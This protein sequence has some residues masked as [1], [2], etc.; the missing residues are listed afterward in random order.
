MQ[1]MLESTDRCV[2]TPPHTTAGDQ[3][4]DFLSVRGIKRSNSFLTIASYSQECDS[5]AAPLVTT[6]ASVGDSGYRSIASESKPARQV[7]LMS[8]TTSTTR[9]ELCLGSFSTTST[10]TAA[11]L[12]PVSSPIGTTPRIGSNGEPNWHWREPCASVQTPQ[13]ATR[14]VCAISETCRSNS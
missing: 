14:S 8:R 5:R 1:T 11:R 10:T 4:P 7:E 9:S 6:P 13:R 12:L 2:S 3:G